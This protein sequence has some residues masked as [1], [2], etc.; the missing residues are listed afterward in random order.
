M[1]TLRIGVRAGVDAAPNA[2][3][4]LSSLGV[5]T[6]LGPSDD[7]TDEAVTNAVLKASRCTAAGSVV[8]RCLHAALQRP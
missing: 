5:G 3:L 4:T 1:L 6:Y 2:S 7:A 8:E